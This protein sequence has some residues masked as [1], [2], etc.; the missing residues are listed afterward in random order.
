MAGRNGDVH[1]SFFT[2]FPG[3]LA[4]RTEHHKHVGPSRAPR[5]YLIFSWF[6]VGTEI[7]STGLGRTIGIYSLDLQFYLCSLAGRD[8]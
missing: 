8:S 6:A 3:G 5:P 4:D 7:S 1:V 2:P